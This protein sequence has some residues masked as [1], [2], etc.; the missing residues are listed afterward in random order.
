MKSRC[1]LGRD[2]HTLLMASPSFRKGWLF[3]V[4]QHQREHAQMLKRVSFVA[5]A[6]C[7][8]LLGLSPARA[9]DTVSADDTARFLA[10][11]SPAADSPLAALTKNRAWQQHARIFDSAFGRLD[12]C[13]LSRIRVWSEDNL[14]A[15]QPTMLY[16]FSG[17]DFLYANAFFPKATTYV[18]SGLEPVSTVPDLTAL[19]G[20]VAPTL[21]QLRVSLS[22]ILSYTFF[23]THDMRSDLRVGRLTG[24]L[25]ILYVFLARSGKTIR[26]VTPVRLNPEG[27]L[28]PDV[29]TDRG[30]A[31]HGVK[32][33]F[34]GSD[35]EERTLYYFSTNLANDSVKSS[36][37][38]KFCETWT[39]PRFD[40]TGSVAR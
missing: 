26:E 4:L 30:S 12:Q 18:L 35:G 20:S 28:Q 17:P 9:T 21:H 39:A 34:A 16:M 22:T 29:D 5:A 33:V 32:I 40:R 8:L 38:L 27:A 25:P 3:L 10:G 2:R 37:F 7:V 19:R 14:K 1:G 24:T 13:Q 15:P 23:K 6:A 11:I 36:K 31:T